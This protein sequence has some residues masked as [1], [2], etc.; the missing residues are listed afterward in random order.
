MV[1]EELSL[2]LENENEQNID[3]KTSLHNV[4]GGY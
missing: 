3:V 4:Y 1:N 2:D